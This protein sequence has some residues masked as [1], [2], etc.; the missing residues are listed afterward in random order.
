MIELI[1]LILTIYLSWQVLW[2]ASR[3]STELMNKNL[4][5]S[6][7]Y[8]MCMF[9]RPQE[10]VHP[11]FSSSGQYVLFLLLG[12]F[13]RHTAALSLDA[14]SMIFSKQQTLSL[15]NSYLPFSPNALLNSLWCSHPIVLTWQQLRRIPVL[16]N[17]RHQIS[18]WLITC[19]YHCKLWVS[20]AYVDIVFS[21]WDIAPE[22]CLVYFSLVWYYGISTIV[23]YL[24]PNPL[25]IYIYIKYI[26]FG[27]V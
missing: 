26:W 8:G 1:P 14:V 5:C 9:R 10:N 21:R 18:K 4:C 17:L 19:W 12:W 16:F 15:C 13:G 11:C 6:A 20:W 24:M 7:N 22:V 27:L 3:V 2:T 25:Y 23:G